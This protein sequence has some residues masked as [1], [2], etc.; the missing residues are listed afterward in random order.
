MRM[1]RSQSGAK[2]TRSPDALGE[3]YCGCGSTV[4]LRVK[5][6]DKNSKALKIY[7]ALT[8]L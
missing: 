2:D 1:E 5:T 7:D 4:R 3:V 6:K 8:R